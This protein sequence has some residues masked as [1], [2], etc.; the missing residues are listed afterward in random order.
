[1]IKKDRGETVMRRK[2]RTITGGGD[3]SKKEEW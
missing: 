3:K 1:M 2:G